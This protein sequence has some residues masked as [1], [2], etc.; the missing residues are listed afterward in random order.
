MDKIT[1]MKYRTVGASNS[2]F[3][4][5]VLNSIK[6]YADP[7]AEK[8]ERYLAGTPILPDVE[9]GLAKICCLD[10]IELI[11]EEDLSTM[12]QKRLENAKI[13]KQ[14]RDAGIKRS[15]N[16]S[17]ISHWPNFKWWEVY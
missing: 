8:Y 16:Y 6:M 12:H 11:K 17:G 1:I 9:F 4:N 15:Y 10:N 14:V 7:D 5:S 3:F 13:V 2:A